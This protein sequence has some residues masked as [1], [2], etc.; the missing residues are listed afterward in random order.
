[1]IFLEVDRFIFTVLELGYA[2][3]STYIQGSSIFAWCVFVVTSDDIDIP[4]H[5]FRWRIGG[6][7]VTN[8]SSRT[9]TTFIDVDDFHSY[10][11]LNVS[12]TRL[13]DNGKSNDPTFARVQ[14]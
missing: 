9:I 2:D 1:M 6:Q 11:T 8:S 7:G 5:T 14:L 13:G 4:V 3:G 12:A 10:S